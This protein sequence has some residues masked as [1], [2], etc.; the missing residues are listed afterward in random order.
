MRFHNDSECPSKEAQC[1]TVPY[2]MALY[3]E[4]ERTGV[5]VSVMK[6]FAGG[7][8]LDAAASPFGH[9][10]TRTQCIQYAFDKPGVLT[11]LPGVRGMDD[12]RDLLGYLN[13]TP[14]ER[15]YS[16]L[17]GLVPDA[18]AAASCVYCNHCQP[19]PAELQIG[20]INKYYDLACLG[21]GLA[22]DH[23]EHLERHASGCIG[24][25]HC[26]RRC[27]FHVTQSAR[28]QEIAAY[29]GE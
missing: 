16:V 13:A 2:R 19:C 29:F 5:G 3:R 1:Y 25:G 10:L 23:Y 28:M 4:F 21:D 24:C 17:D 8:L 6:P 11:M 20:L 12:L 27:P 15:D 26:D 7:Q 22:R 9:A 18:G 14:G